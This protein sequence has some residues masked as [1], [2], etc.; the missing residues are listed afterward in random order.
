MTAAGPGR[1]GHRSDHAAISHGI[2]RPT[3]RTT[4]GTTAYLPRPALCPTDRRPHTH[5]CAIRPGL[6]SN[7]QPASP[8]QPATRRPTC[9]A[10]MAPPNHS[11]S[12]WPYTYYIHRTRCAL[13]LLANKHAGPAYRLAVPQS[14]AGFQI[15][16]VHEDHASKPAQARRGQAGGQRRAS[17]K[18]PFHDPAGHSMTQRP[19]LAHASMCVGLA[20]EHVCSMQLQ[21]APS[22]MI[23]MI[24][25][26]KSNL[27]GRSQRQQQLCTGICRH[28]A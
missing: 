14:I 23:K 12:C 11:G 19:A 1:Q 27:K 28:H 18:R 2:S 13:G 17:F 3:N 16:V 21:T 10:A 7:W 4:S 8:E 9:A 15:E 20:P 6:G 26:Q 25:R 24:Q 5:A 22:C